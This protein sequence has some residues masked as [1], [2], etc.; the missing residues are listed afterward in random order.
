[1]FHLCCI[2]YRARVVFISGRGELEKCSI[3]Y[4]VCGL[5]GTHGM[6]SRG[7]DSFV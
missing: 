5:R 6:L 1:M 7:V 3:G 2:E 4:L